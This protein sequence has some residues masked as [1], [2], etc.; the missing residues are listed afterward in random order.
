MPTTSPGAVSAGGVGEPGDAEV[1]QLGARLAVL[2]DEDVLG[3]DVAVDDAARVGVVE[4]LAEV[5][6]D[7]AD[8][9]VAERAVAVERGPGSSPRPAR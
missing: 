7:L 1:H 4:R 3:L 8:L 5:G 2:G 6:A 9:A